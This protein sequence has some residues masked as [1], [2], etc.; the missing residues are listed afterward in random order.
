MFGGVLTDLRTPRN[1]GGLD[2]DL[3]NGIAAIILGF[4]AFGVLHIT[5][6]SFA[7]WQWC[8]HTLAFIRSLT[9]VICPLCMQA[10]DHY[11]SNHSDYVHRLLVNLLLIPKIVRL[12]R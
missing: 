8:V 2:I 9:Q 1:C 4:V 6:G 12:Q 5:S 3:M 7:P 10:H 11:W